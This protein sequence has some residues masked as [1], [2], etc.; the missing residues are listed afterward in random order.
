[1]G[2]VETQDWFALGVHE[3]AGFPKRWVREEE[4]VCGDPNAIEAFAVCE[5]FDAGKQV[6]RRLAVQAIGA[7][8]HLAASLHRFGLPECVT[9]GTFYNPYLPARWL[10][11]PGI[12][13]GRY[14]NRC[15]L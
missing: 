15:I 2:G 5:V 6:G 10:F 12:V 9:S 11:G 1:M 3:S 4:L 14:R 8:A 13:M 7:V